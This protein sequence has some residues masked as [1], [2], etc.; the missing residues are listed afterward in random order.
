MQQSFD[1]G[2]MRVILA[3]GLTDERSDAPCAQLCELTG[4]DEIELVALRDALP[5]EQSVTIAARSC[6]SLAGIDKPSQTDVAELGCGDLNRLLIAIHRLNFGPAVEA[7]ATCGAPDCDEAMDIDLD[8]DRMLAEEPGAAVAPRQRIDMDIARRGY[9]LELAVPRVR[10]LAAVARRAV[11]DGPAASRLLLDDTL[12]GLASTDGKRGIGRKRALARVD[13]RQRIEA[14]VLATD[15]FAR[16]DIRGQCPRCGGATNLLFDPGTFLLAR[17]RRQQDI[18]DEVDLIAS[19]YHWSEAEILDLPI[20][21]RRAYL[22]RIAARLT[23]TS[24]PPTLAY[25]RETAA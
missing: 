11:E 24:S 16:L 17:L 1:T 23:E 8:L 7:V 12:V 19:H 3:F 5:I 10:S 2:R 22:T 20:S 21:R 15:R 14:W 13:V 25:A 18:L 4:R 6:L 9:R